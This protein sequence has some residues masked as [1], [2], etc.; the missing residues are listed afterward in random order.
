MK[1]ES[2]NLP[3]SVYSEKNLIMKIFQC[4]DFQKLENTF[5]VLKPEDFYDKNY[6]N[7]YRVIKKSYIE[8]K[9]FSKSKILDSFS[10]NEDMKQVLLSISEDYNT[11]SIYTLTQIIKNKSFLRIF[12]R[13]QNDLLESA[14]SS[15]S[16]H[17]LTEKANQIF[18]Q[19]NRIITTEELNPLSEDIDKLTD[20]ITNKKESKLIPTFYPSIDNSLGGFESGELIILGGRTSMGKSSIMNNIAMKQAQNGIKVGIFSLEMSKKTVFLRFMC[21]LC[22]IDSR[23]VRTK[24]F[25]EEEIGKLRLKRLEL[26]SFPIYISDNPYTNILK[27]KSEIRRVK[28]KEGLDIV[29][30]DHLDFLIDSNNSKINLRD[31]ISHVSKNLAQISKELKTPIVLLC[32]LN[33]EIEGRKDKTPKLSDLRNSGSLEQ[34]SDIVLFIHRPDYYTNDKYDDKDFETAELHIAKHRNGKLDKIDLEFEKR[35]MRFKDLID[36]NVS[37]IQSI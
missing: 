9:F 23:K 21:D 31:Q 4:T 28:T 36:E 2:V 14:Y 3:H 18:N 26:K 32:Q 17:E 30:I 7:I 1:L 37:N 12:I 19:L 34:D 5:S 33:R 13:K 27:I 24:E 25:T 11:D 29:Y 16:I 8:N 6:G 15:D 20:E 35:F 10:N 22:N